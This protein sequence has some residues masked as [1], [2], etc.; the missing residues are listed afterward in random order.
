MPRYS[1][2]ASVPMTLIRPP[3]RW[4]SWPHALARAALRDT[5]A[6]PSLASCQ[7]CSS[8]QEARPQSCRRRLG[9]ALVLELLPVVEQL[10]LAV[11]VHELEE[12]E[13]IGGQV[14][15]DEAPRSEGAHATHFRAIL[16]AAVARQRVRLEALRL[17]MPTPASESIM[18]ARVHSICVT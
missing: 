1:L 7:A 12:G 13:D 17:V 14:T 6:A 18:S 15:H 16:R 11:V 9:C 8:P 5:R 4:R 2:M 3:P 10:I